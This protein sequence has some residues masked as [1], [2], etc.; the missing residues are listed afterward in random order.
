MR[1]IFAAHFDNG[2]RFSSSVSLS[3][4]AVSFAAAFCLLLAAV[5]ISDVNTSHKDLRSR[6]LLTFLVCFNLFSLP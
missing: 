2:I 4:F 1:I 5:T 3:S 6:A